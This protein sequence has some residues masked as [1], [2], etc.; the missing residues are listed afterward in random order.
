MRLFYLPLSPTVCSDS[1]PLSWWYY[2]TISPFLWSSIFPTIR[3]FSNELALHIT[4]PK[5]WS[6]GISPS[7]EYSRLISFRIDSFELL[8][9]QRI[10]KNILQHHSSKVSILRCS[11]LTSIHDNWKYHSFDNIDLCRQSDV[12]AFNKLTRLVIAFLPR[13]L[14]CGE[15]GPRLLD[16][17][18]SPDSALIPPKEQERHLLPLYC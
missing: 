15:A 12:F 13:T 6:F 4:Q 2:L 14:H 9:V 11:A 17:R 7:N 3:I 18:E 16:D 8:A 5:D 10:L 1:C